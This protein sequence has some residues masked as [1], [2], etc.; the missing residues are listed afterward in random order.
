MHRKLLLFLFFLPGRLVI[1][2]VLAKTTHFD[3]FELY[4]KTNSS[5]IIQYACLCS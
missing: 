1:G 4:R 5:I 2:H 3:G